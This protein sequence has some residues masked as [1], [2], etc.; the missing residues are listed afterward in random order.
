MLIDRVTA[1]VRHDE[2]SELAFVQSQPRVQASPVSVTRK[3]WP[4]R[5]NQSSLTCNKVPH[6]PVEAQDTGRFDNA[7][8]VLMNR[9]A[10]FCDMKRL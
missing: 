10:L 2:Q 3:L 4:G 6:L 7:E 1:Q 9:P 8:N 5:R